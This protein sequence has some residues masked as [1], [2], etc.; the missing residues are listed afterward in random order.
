PIDLQR[1]M[2]TQERLQKKSRAS[3]EDA[4]FLIQGLN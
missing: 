3:H 4:G 2:P 1:V